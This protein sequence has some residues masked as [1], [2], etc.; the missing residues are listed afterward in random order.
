MIDLVL[1]SFLIALTPVV[2][3]LVWKLIAGMAN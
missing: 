3:G 2:L 1:W